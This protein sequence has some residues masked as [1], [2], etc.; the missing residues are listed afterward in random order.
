MGTEVKDKMGELYDA[1][2][3]QFV[4]GMTLVVAVLILMTFMLLVRT[5][6]TD[7]VHLGFLTSILGYQLVIH[8]ETHVGRGGEQRR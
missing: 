4:R 7:T 8:A 5:G 6:F 2:A 1:W 3:P